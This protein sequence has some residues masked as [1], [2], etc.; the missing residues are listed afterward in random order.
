M[1]VRDVSCLGIIALTSA[2]LVSNVADNA[3]IKLVFAAI[4]ELAT[5]IA[6]AL[7]SI[8]DC[9]EELTPAILVSSVADVPTLAAALTTIPVKFEP[10][11]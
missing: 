11:P 6:E 8:E 9:K 7:A 3:A 10:S 1:L 5:T 4:E 2:I